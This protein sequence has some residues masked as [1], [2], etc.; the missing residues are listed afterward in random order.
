MTRR[1]IYKKVLAVT[2]ARYAGQEAQAVAERFCR[3]LYG[4]GRFEV[5]LEGDAEVESVVA[6]DFQECVQR[7]A[8]GEPVQYI[9]GH[10]EF[11]GRRFGVCPG[12]LIPRPETEQLV[13]MVAESQ[14]AKCPRIIDMGTG[15][16]AIAVSLALEVEGS[17]VEAIDLSDVA[18]EVASANAE[19]LGATV[20][21]SKEDIFA[22][23][24]AEG[25]YD[26]VVSNPPYIP[27]SEREEME[28]NVVD[29]EPS[30]ALFVPN[31]EPLIFYER[32]AD[33][34]LRG[35]REGGL[36]AFEIHERLAIET[37]QML[38]RKGFRDVTTYDDL[39]SKPRIILCTK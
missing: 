28:R 20:A 5:V 22:F 27:E 31:D 23:E 36:L 38:V 2:E 1:E 34:A 25:A 6:H 15:S 32:I 16:G 26:V 7:L 12:V 8:S 18:L 24:A 29:F 39:N 14:A 30:E 17:R 11:L 19:A 9:V 21:F 4:F 37:A 13:L 10:T 35:L 33:V 3:D